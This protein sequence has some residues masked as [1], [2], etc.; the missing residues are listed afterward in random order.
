MDLVAT[1]SSLLFKSPICCK[2][3]KFRSQTRRWEDEEQRAYWI[4]H[5]IDLLYGSVAGRVGWI[6]KK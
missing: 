3:V 2:V 1:I 4:L 5:Y 6:K